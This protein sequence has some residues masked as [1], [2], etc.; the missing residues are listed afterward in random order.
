MDSHQSD[1]ADEMEKK[2]WAVVCREPGELAE[3]LMAL[4]SGMSA[5]GAP[6]DGFPE[7][8]KGKVQRILDETLGF[9]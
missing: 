9:A 4:A 5:G 6:S 2:G 7:L 8:D 1:L 3:T